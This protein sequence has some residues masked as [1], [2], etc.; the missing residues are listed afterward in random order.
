MRRSITALGTLAMMSLGGCS[1][2][3]LDPGAG[4]TIGAGGGASASSASTGGM[5]GGMNALALKGSDI[6]ANSIAWNGTT[7]T[8]WA[9]PDALVLFFSDAVQQCASPALPTM[10]AA[11]S[12]PSFWQLILVVPPELDRVGSIDLR[13]GRIGAYDLEVTGGS[14]C[15]QALESGN[16]FAGTLEIAGSDATSVVVTLSDANTLAPADGNYTAQRCTTPPP[17]AAPTAA[18]AVRGSSLPAGSTTTSGATPDPTALYVVAGSAPRSCQSPW[19][20][21]C[22]STQRIVFS[23][24]SSMQQPG[25]YALTDPAL[26]ASWESLL[27]GAPAS[28][29]ATDHLTGPFTAGTVEILSLDAAGVSFR[30]YQSYTQI[31]VGT[32]ELD[33]LYAATI[34]P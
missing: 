14:P 30:L 34:C 5:V 4:G 31:T 29:G 23:L 16:G 12:G 13:D 6:A 25:V 24:P 1:P 22:T 20:V 3:V 8:P 21:D 11:C 18:L 28:C 9:N 7:A 17:V 33:G 27:P 15:G 10:P 26:A 19:P 2:I 32:F